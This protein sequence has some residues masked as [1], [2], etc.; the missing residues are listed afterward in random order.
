MTTDDE[1]ARNHAIVVRELIALG[2]AWRSH[3]ENFDGHQLRNQLKRI[4]EWL[5]DLRGDLREGTDFYHWHVS[6]E[7]GRMCP[8]EYACP[9][10]EDLIHDDD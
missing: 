5:V 2:E 10:C 6:R 8:L 7:F 3:W 1:L 9:E 4:A